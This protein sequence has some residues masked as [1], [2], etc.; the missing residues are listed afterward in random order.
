MGGVLQ[1]GW[2]YT[3]QLAPVAELDANNRVVARFVYASK[4]NVPDY[5]VK[6]GITYRFITDQLGS[7][8]LV[9]NSQTGE[10]AQQLRYDEFGVVLENTNPGFQPFGF[11]GGLYDTDTGL[12]RFGARDYDP[13]TGRWTSKDPIR[14]SGGD[15]NLY[16]YVLGDPVNFIDPTGEFLQAMLVRGLYGAGKEFLWQLVVEGRSLNCVDYGEVAIKGVKA[17][18]GNP[19][20]GS[21]G[22][23]AGKGEVF[24]KT[25]A[26]ATAAAKKLGFVK[27]KVVF[28]HDQA[29]YYN[30]K[31]RQYISRD[32]GSG[33][34][35]SHNGGV[36]KI[37]SSVKDL[38]SKISRTA[39]VDANLKEVG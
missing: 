34:N 23:R 12:V 8:R 7:V 33:R 25:A 20:V 9:V 39:T 1:Q 11:A 38:G 22:I 24:Y 17:A 27:L 3:G 26:E 13:H 37:A 6:S 16:G 15:S 32:V 36:W 5:M 30:K 4:S 10:I 35:G 14:F 29:V 31:T 28:I 2:L 19:G 18:F 21:R